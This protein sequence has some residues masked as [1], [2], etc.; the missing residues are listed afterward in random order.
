VDDKRVALGPFGRRAHRA[1]Q[2]D[3]RLGVAD[4]RHVFQRHRIFGQKRRGNDRQRRVLVAGR[5]DRAGEPVAAFNNVLDGWHLETFSTISA[6]AGPYTV[7]ANHAAIAFADRA[8]AFFPQE[9]AFFQ[10][11]AE[12]LRVNDVVVYPE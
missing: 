3:Q 4:A 11:A 9:I 2:L 5:L 10:I 12:I 8:I 7:I 1:A 6:V